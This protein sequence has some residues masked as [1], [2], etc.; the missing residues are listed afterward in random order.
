VYDSSRK[1][2]KALKDYMEAKVT[3]WQVSNALL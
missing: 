3:A 2:L 1:A